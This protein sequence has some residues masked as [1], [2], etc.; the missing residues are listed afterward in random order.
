M[1]SKDTRNT[2]LQAAKQVILTKG[3][4]ACGL[5]EILAAAGVPK[6]S[7]YHYFKSKEDF[8]AEL[9]KSYIWTRMKSI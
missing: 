7:F 6:G 2:L 1:V 8:G 9:P 4:A 5:S 3:Y